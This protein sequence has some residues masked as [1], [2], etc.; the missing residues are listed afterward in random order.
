M[1]GQT[2]GVG[3]PL[4]HH[5]K[6][7]VVE[8]IGDSPEGTDMKLLAAFVFGAYIGLA[9]FLSDDMSLFKKI[10]CFIL[11]CAMVYIFDWGCIG[12]AKTSDAQKN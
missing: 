12:G 9:I 4:P 8:V 1:A 5:G 6:I 7:I 10:T 11:F 2:S 3:K